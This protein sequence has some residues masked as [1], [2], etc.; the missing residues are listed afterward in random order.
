MSGTFPCEWLVVF[1]Y[2]LYCWLVCARMGLVGVDFNS[3]R[4][5]GDCGGVSVCGG[6]R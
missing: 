6:E 4:L 5:G 1:A 3:M 2:F